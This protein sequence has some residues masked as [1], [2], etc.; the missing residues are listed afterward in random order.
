MFRF[1]DG[2]LNEAN[3]Q[4]KVRE[5]YIYIYTHKFIPRILERTQM[6]AGSILFPPLKATSLSIGTSHNVSRPISM[7]GVTSRSEYVPAISKKKCEMRR[8]AKE[9]TKSNKSKQDQFGI[10][11]WFLSYS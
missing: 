10:V 4:K 6:E 8:N 1:R 2:K 11:Y 7:P 3:I 5:I 9:G